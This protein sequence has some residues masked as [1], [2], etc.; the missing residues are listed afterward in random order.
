MRSNSDNKQLSIK[1]GPILK[2]EGLKVYYS[3]DQ[4]GGG[5]KNPFRKRK[6]GYTK[7]V[8]NVNFEVEKASVLGIAGESGCG[9]STVAK[10]I[11]G[12][13]S[14][15]A[16]RIMFLG[17]D[18]PGRV[19]KRPRDIL[20]ELQMVFQNPQSTLNPRHTIG[21]QIGRSLMLFGNKSSSEVKRK[22]EDLLEAVGLGKEYYSKK[23]YQ[24]SGGERQRVAIARAFA[25]QP[26]VVICDEP[27]S[28]LDVSVKAT[29]I[30]LLQEF[31]RRYET[32]MIYISHDL[33]ILHYLVDRIVVMY[34]GQCYEKGSPNAVF[35]PPY[36]PYTEALISAL[37][38]PDPEVK[39][40]PVRLSGPVPSALDPPS[41]CRFHTRCPRKIGT[42]CEREPPPWRQV[43][44]EHQIRC[45]RTINDLPNTDLLKDTS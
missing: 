29:V 35:N 22:V 2:V 10:A 24:I 45:H 37:S 1:A 44:D 17:K 25:N 9:K 15:H 6:R 21:H 42:L 30:N 27:V 13:E 11:V 34:L 41:G 39:K 16:G 31:K 23:A 12:L 4:K 33:R 40:P 36:H 7:A 20:K 32:T 3:Q 14:P 43:T 38:S 19:E 5:I 18:L 8:D 26:K 28:S